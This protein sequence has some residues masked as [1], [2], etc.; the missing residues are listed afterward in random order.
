MKIFQLEVGMIGTNCYIVEN[1]KTKH[2]VVIDPG[3]EGER[4]VQAI[5]KEGLTIDAIFIT[6]G[7]SDHIMGLN[8]VRQDTGAKVYISSADAA[9]LGQA[10]ANLSIYMM[11]KTA[12]FAP[13]DV[14]YGDGDVVEAAGFKFKVLATPGHTK[15]G[16]CL[17]CE[18][19][20][21]CGDTVFAESIG[22]TDLPGGSY[23][24]I[25]QSIKDKIL[26]LADDVQL[27]P[28]HG[29][30]TSVGWERRRNPFL[31]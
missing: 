7:H 21:F 1:E 2:G 3:D 18:N 5:H 8:E 6:H 29:P 22:R 17:Q 31:Q 14:I 25:I 4:I 23:E 30:A 19:V 10:K 20:V 12:E 11:G 16:V 26:P 15:G 24:E 28:G 27:L 13:A 9:C